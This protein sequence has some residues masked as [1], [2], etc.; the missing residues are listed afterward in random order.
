MNFLKRCKIAFHFVTGRCN[1]M[2]L[3]F[4]LALEMGLITPTMITDERDYTAVER[5]LKNIGK[6]YLL[7]EK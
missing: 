6:E 3:V 7:E 5:A 4:I 1:G 2:V